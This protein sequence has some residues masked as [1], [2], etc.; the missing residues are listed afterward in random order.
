MAWIPITDLKCIL[1][2]NSRTSH[3]PGSGKVAIIIS[4]AAL[5]LSNPGFKLFSSYLGQQRSLHL[6]QEQQL[7]VEIADW[8]GKFEVCR[9]NCLAF[10]V[11]TV[12]YQSILVKEQPDAIIFI[13][14]AGYFF[15]IGTEPVNELHWLR[16]CRCQ[17]Y[18]A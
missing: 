6:K 13:G 3:W 14:I 5:V 15:S 1:M 18:D 12:T 4:M 17:V 11:Y 16:S 9:R 2:R 10:S 8:F 7:A